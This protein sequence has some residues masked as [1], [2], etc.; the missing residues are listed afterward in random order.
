MRDAVPKDVGETSHSMNRL[1]AIDGLRGLAIILV[2]LFHFF[3]R[4]PEHYPYGDAIF[5]PAVHGY[6]GVHLFFIISGFVIALTLGRKP[7]LVHFA[8]GR[9]VRLWPAM[10]VCSTLTFLILTH[11]KTDFALSR[12]V[13]W[14]AFLPSLTFTAPAIWQPLVGKTHWIDGAY[15]SL[16]V[17]VR[18]YFLAAVACSIFGVERLTHV[19]WALLLVAYPGLMVLEQIQPGGAVPKLW[20]L[21]FFT[22]YLPL[23]CIGLACFEIFSGRRDLLVFLILATSIALSIAGSSGSVEKIFIGGSAAWFLYY[24]LYRT[25]FVVD[26]LR[27]RPL[28]FFGSISYSLYLIHQYVGVYLISLLPDGLHAMAYLA[29]VMSVAGILSLLAYAIFRWIE[30]PANQSWRRVRERKSREKLRLANLRL[31]KCGVPAEQ[32]ASPRLEPKEFD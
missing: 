18:F 6:L 23:F 8:F 1:E 31:E 17:E 5:R 25:G 29:L 2:V 12:Q 27:F 32:A 16:F 14:Q 20:D 13:G 22:Q 3:Q 15:W 21:I 9:F 4:F 26:I 28:T 7:T 10:L 24:S 19:I 11:G 30:V